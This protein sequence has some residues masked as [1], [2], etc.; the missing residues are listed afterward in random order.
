MKNTQWLT[1]VININMEI[2]FDEK[3]G[4]RGWLIGLKLFRLEAYPTCVSSKLCEFI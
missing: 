4:H 3:V 2:Q 1:I